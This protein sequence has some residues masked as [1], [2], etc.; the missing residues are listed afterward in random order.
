[1]SSE[2]ATSISDEE[3]VALAQNILRQSRED[4]DQRAGQTTSEL[5]QQQPGITI[6]LGHKNIVKLP[7]EVIDVI[8]AEIE[9]LA[10]SHNLLTTLPSRL[11]E[12]KR[13]RYLNVRYNSMREIP[14]C[15]LGMPS[16]E[17]LDV[18]RNR[19][20]AIPPGI[21]N[22][23]SLKVLAIAKNRI[24]ELPVCLGDINSLQ[25]LKL[26]G[27]PLK[28]P[29]PEVCSINANAPSPANENERDAV[30]AT[31]VK[32]FMRLQSS[33]EKQRVETEK[34]RIESS[35][36]ESWT[37]SNPETPRPS[38]RTNGGRFPVRPSIGSVEGFN[39]KPPES[40]GIPPPI[41]TRSHYRNQSSQNNITSRRPKISP[42][43]L[44]NNANERNRSQ[45]EGAG[46]VSHRQKRMGIYTNKTTDLGFVDELKRTSH[47]RGFSQGYVIHANAVPNGM[48]GPATAI[49]YGD[50]VT[51]RS[52]AS[53]PLSDVREHKR[54]SRQPDVVVEAAKNFLYAVSQLHDTIS[55]M[56]R[57]DRSQDSLHRKEDFYRRFT[58]TYLHIRALDDLL[59]RF[60]TLAEEDEEEANTLAQSIYV[61]TLKC[62][63]LFMA[64]NLSIAENRTEIAQ[65]VDPRILRTYLLLQQGSLAEMRNACAILGAVFSDPPRKSMRS[66]VNATVRAR[67]LK[68]RRFQASPPQRN[69]SYQIPPPVILHSNDNS[70]TN[71]LTS[72]SAATPRSG[73]SFATLAA[74]SRSNTLNGTL[75]EQDEDIYFERVYDKLKLACDACANTI[76]IITRSLEEKFEVLRRDLDIDDPKLKVLAGLVE[77]SNLVQDSMEPLARRLSQMQLK[78]SYSRSQPVFWQLCMAFIK[79]WGDLAS[80]CSQE[81]RNMGLVGPVEVKQLLKPLH[82]TVKDASLAI[83]DSPWSHLTANNAG[84]TTQPHLASF[85]SRTQPPRFAKPA[86]PA[87]SGSSFPGP[88][89]TTITSTSAY[90]QPYST[91]G[92]GSGSAGY[93]TPVPA[94]PLLSAA[95]GAAA[96][97][98]VPN[99]PSYAPVGSSSTINVFERADR[100]LSQQS[101]RV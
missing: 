46:P 53:R 93:G 33:K 55:H 17:I 3:V 44:S 74:M 101:R 90:S 89:N 59:R 100:L 95:L 76:P 37:E 43:I 82:R 25:V 14:E 27:N 26:D 52:L 54:R 60:D 49:G 67:P 47:F 10:L 16:L 2:T 36:D 48:S 11:V 19:I 61:Y 88:I 50:N 32:K 81:G 64:I 12:C 35:G 63:D 99:T 31:Q 66:D 5:Q 80:A 22:L 87:S 9:R 21:A 92:V 29:P 73:E 65:S 68:V 62:L 41:P 71:T 4:I 72:I 86:M 40:P 30:I 8:R 34:L 75:D 84:A 94:T 51:V 70:R 38:R 77:K 85:T 79:A 15:I 58:S 57:V 1:M 6:D 69:V 39:E 91:T 96:Q 97:A 24:E 42:L 7:D 28:F 45:S 83:N 23:T 98:T 13:L 56:M 18:S 78:D 20:T